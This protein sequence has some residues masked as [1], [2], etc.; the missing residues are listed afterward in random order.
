ML[1][2]IREKLVLKGDKKGFTLIELMIVVAIIGILAAIA[3]PNF[4]KFQARTKQSECKTNLKCIFTAAK[5][6][7]AEKD[8]YLGHI[9]AIG[10]RPEMG[11]RYHYRYGTSGYQ[12]VNDTLSLPETNG[13]MTAVSVSGFTATC[14]GNIDSDTFVDEWAMN[15]NND[16]SNGL[17]P[18]G[19]QG[20][21]VEN[22]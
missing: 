2:R 4:V 12:A 19:N 17:L 15:N 7:S 14:V 5:G 13:E 9:A 8:T 10:F 22:E 21:D 1:Q 16:L 3:I 11:N 20:N 6:W 18:A